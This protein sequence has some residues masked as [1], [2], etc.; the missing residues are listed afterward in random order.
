MPVVWISFCIVELGMEFLHFVVVLDVLLKMN[1]MLIM[2][3]RQSIIERELLHSLIP[4]LF[5]SHI[6]ST[7]SDP[8]V[9]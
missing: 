9:P 2:F 5:P 7:Q 6:A 1:K 3:V 4:Y 8:R